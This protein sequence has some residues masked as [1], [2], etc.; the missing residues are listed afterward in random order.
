M[1]LKPDHHRRIYFAGLL[2]LAVGLPLSRVLMSMGQLV[3]VANWLLE[4][5]LKGKWQRFVSIP[6]AWIFASIFGLHV[7]G[8]LWTSDFDY[9]FNDLRVKLPLLALPVIMATSGPLSQRLYRW[10]EWLF[11]AAVLLGSFIST[12]VWMGWTKHQITDVRDISLFISHIRFSLLIAV[13]V[14]MLLRHMICLLYTSDA[15]DD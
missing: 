15:A 3:L 10:L 13:V 6:A 8:L 7:L 11:I 12:A 14:L 1:L 4:G 2:L 5:D 9:A